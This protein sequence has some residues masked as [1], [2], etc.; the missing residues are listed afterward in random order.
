MPQK[1]LVGYE[2][3]QLES[4]LYK[5]FDESIKPTLKEKAVLK[6]IQLNEIIGPNKHKF[7]H[8]NLTYQSNGK[9]KVLPFLLEKT[10]PADYERRLYNFL[11]GFYKTK[12]LDCILKF[13]GQLHDYTNKRINYLVFE[14]PS[15]I[16][17]F[18]SLEEK[19]IEFKNELEENKED[20]EKVSEILAKEMSLLRDV[21]KTIAEFHYWGTKGLLLAPD[22]KKGKKGNKYYKLFDEGDKKWFTIKTYNKE[23]HRNRFINDIKRIYKHLNIPD[24]KIKKYLENVKER[25]EGRSLF[26]WSELDSMQYLIHKNLHGG[27]ILVLDNKI[28]IIGLQNVGFGSALIDLGFLQN[29]YCNLK[30]VKEERRH[31]LH[32]Y[33]TH[34]KTLSE[35]DYSAITSMVRRNFDFYGLNKQNSIRQVFQNIHTIK[36]TASKSKATPL[37]ENIKCTKTSFNEIIPFGYIIP[38]Y[39]CLKGLQEFLKKTTNEQ[40]F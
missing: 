25:I 40:I 14:L 36:E 13:Y 16:K 33:L 5:L 19:L 9:E 39:S 1:G 18:D 29:L 28:K 15:P 21:T 11:C 23:Y 8:A 10:K 32:T 30:E 35:N 20:E 4:N 34:L 22:G 27:N 12:P 7:F 17:K 31:I 2:R 26:A 6:N 3:N 38:E 37:E 24:N